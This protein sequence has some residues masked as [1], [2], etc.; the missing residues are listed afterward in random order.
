MILPSN[1]R[2]LVVDDNDYARATVQAMLGQLG[3]SGIAE[4][5]SGAEAIGMLLSQKYDIVLT[6]WYM[7]EVNG[8]GL[9]KIVRAASFGMNRTIP[10]V[11]MTAYATRENIGAAKALGIADILVKP[12]EPPHLA[13]A[14]TRAV[15]ALTAEETD[16]QV[17]IGG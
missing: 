12:I 2:V 8:A 4:T 15:G 13:A 11:V 10:I 7:P 17:F 6:D 16:E 1:M 14:L 3:F 5:S 9:I